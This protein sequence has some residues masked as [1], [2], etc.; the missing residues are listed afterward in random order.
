MRSRVWRASHRLILKCDACHSVP[1]FSVSMVSCAEYE[2]A[3][4]L[5]LYGLCET[6]IARV[7]TSDYQRKFAKPEAPVL[8]WILLTS[9]A[10]R[11][12]GSRTYE[13]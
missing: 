9:S 3:T 11:E 8:D 12:P 1:D 13:L 2:L 4:L 5:Y 7:A 10:I 6:V